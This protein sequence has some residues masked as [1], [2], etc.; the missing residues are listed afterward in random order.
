MRHALL[1]LCR[2]AGGWK[3]QGSGTATGNA[4]GISNREKK[5]TPEIQGESAVR[6]EQRRVRLPAAAPGTEAFPSCFM[7][8]GP[9]VREWPWRVGRPARGLTFINLAFSPGRSRCPENLVRGC[10]LV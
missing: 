8:R 7:P 2:C 5:G 9:A 10:G 3:Y 6:G 4:P 1:P